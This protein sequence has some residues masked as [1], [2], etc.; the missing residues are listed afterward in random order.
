MHYVPETNEQ[1][2][3]NG[4]ELLAVF[5]RQTAR[6]GDVFADG[7]RAEVGRMMAVAYNGGRIQMDSVDTLISD[8]IAD[9]YHGADGIVSPGSLLGAA[10]MELSQDVNLVPALC[11]MGEEGRPGLYANAV[12]AVLAY[13]DRVGVCT[14][15]VTDTAY[16]HWAAE[17]EE[18]RFMQVRA[19]RYGRS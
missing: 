13:A 16:T 1:R 5:I 10:L 8:L 7:D 6:I 4:D 9:M 18:A 19:E 15:Y 3:E 2:A 17:T 12:A 11:A 14:G